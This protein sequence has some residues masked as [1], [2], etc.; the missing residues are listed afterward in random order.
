VTRAP[1]AEHLLDGAEAADEV[2]LSA[3]DEAA[4]EAEPTADANGSIEYK[5]QLVRV[6]TARAIAEALERAGMVD[7]PHVY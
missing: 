3:A 1:A 2:L 4:A 6:L 5:R 7:P